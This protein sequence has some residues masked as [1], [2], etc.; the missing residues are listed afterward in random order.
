MP[1]GPAVIPVGVGPDD[2]LQWG[3]TSRL[4]HHHTCCLG[5]REGKV[6]GREGGGREGGGREVREGGRARGG[7][8]N[9]TKKGGREE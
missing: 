4:H 7:E 5:G 1:G 8:S 9:I 2:M 3:S 6:G